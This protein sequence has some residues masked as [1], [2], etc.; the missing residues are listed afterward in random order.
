MRISICM[1]WIGVESVLEVVTLC[2]R[3]SLRLNVGP[4]V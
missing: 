1:D 4:F 3:A 2:Y